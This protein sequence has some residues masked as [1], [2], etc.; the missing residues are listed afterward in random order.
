MTKPTL[1]T[2][3]PFGRFYAH[4]KRQTQ[5]PSITNIKDVKNI[6]GLK[7]W[8]ARRAAEYAADNLDKLAGLD[9]DERVQLIRQAPFTSR[10]D[11]ASNVGD[12][13]HEWIDAFIKGEHR[14]AADLPRTAQGMIRAF[15]KFNETYTPEWVMSE[16]TVW[17]ETHQYAGTADWAARIH[18]WLVLGDTKTGNRVYPDTRYQLA[19]LANADFILEDDGTELDLPRFE[20]FAILHLRPTYYELIP[21]INIAEAFESFLALKTVFYDDMAHAANSLM[22]APKVE[23]RAAA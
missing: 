12:I 16:F 3:T 22:W 2:S 14:G 4:P 19:A 8:A 6:P 23:V 18:G 11:D 13:V 20:R 21:V 9:R 15:Q 1:S 5:V 10:S 17:S 7:V